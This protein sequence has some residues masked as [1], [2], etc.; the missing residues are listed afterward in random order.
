MSRLWGIC[1]DKWM[2]RWMSDEAADGTYGFCSRRRPLDTH[3]SNPR[4]G[5]A[6][7]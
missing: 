6:Q 1:E 5:L 2:Q 3:L 4:N 7:I